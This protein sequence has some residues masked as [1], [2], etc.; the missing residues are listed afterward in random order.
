V[1]TRIARRLEKFPVDPG[2]IS[3]IVFFLF[4]SFMLLAIFLPDM[5]SSSAI[6]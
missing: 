2:G 5:R 4:A 1:V 3:C 6:C